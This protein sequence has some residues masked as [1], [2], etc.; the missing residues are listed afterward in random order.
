MEL[1]PDLNDDL[2]SSCSK[3]VESN[4][5]TFFEYSQRSNNP[6]SSDISGTPALFD[7]SLIILM[8]C[9]I[10]NLDDMSPTAS[11]SESC[12]SL[13]NNPSILGKIS[14]VKGLSMAHLNC[15]SFIRYLDD[16]RLLLQDPALLTRPGLTHPFM[17]QN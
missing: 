8:T 11:S 2:H 12:I 16:I 17:T 7:W 13:A 1:N 3:G 5:S 15:R 6:H 9:L 4:L 10:N 14:S